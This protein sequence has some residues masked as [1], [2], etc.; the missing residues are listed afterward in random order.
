MTETLTP[1]PAVS[2]S[3]TTSRK[4]PFYRVLWVQVLVAIVLAISS[5]LIS[6]PLLHFVVFS[7]LIRRTCEIL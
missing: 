3:A 4:T 2:A 1:A 6:H 5:A 7:Q